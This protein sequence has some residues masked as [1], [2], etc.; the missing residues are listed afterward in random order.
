MRKIAVLGAG[1]LLAKLSRRNDDQ[2]RI[3]IEREGGG[4]RL[5]PSDLADLIKLG[6]LIA[7]AV[8]DDGWSSPEERDRVRSL[9]RQLQ[10]V[11]RR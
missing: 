7:F 10:G 3:Q 9:Y 11:C 8:L 4:G 1:Q 2:Y 6:E 5:H